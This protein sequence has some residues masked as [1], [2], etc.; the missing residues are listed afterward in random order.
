MAFLC[1]IFNNF[2]DSAYITQC[3]RSWYHRDFCEK[4]SNSLPNVQQIFFTEIPFPL[5]RSGSVLAPRPEISMSSPAIF[6]AFFFEKYFLCLICNTLNVA[7]TSMIRYKGPF[8][9]Y[10]IMFL[11]LLGP[12]TQLFDDLQ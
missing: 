2:R 3:A 6:R 11:T 1:N 8:K 9:Y 12:P 10:V 7:Y 4:N 5:W